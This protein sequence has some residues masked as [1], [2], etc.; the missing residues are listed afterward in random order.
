MGK[1][2]A[3]PGKALRRWRPEAQIIALSATVGNA[4]ELA[5]WL[6]ARLI[7]SE[8]RPVPLHLATCA[9]LTVEVRRVRQASTE[10]A[11]AASGP[12]P[13]PLIGPSSN[14]VAAVLDDAHA[15]GGQVLIFVNT[16]RSAVAEAK[17]LGK[18]MS[19]RLRKE[20]P[21]RSRI[22]DDLANGLEKKAEGATAMALAD[23][24]TLAT[25]LR[26]HVIDK[27]LEKGGLHSTTSPP[28]HYVAIAPMV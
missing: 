23:R 3:G 13:R 15:Q 8:W 18:R 1:A 4:E 19:K 2:H 5:G 27:G 12:P 10:K 17:R 26:G 28:A 22:L 9:D 7:T 20:D 14:P 25:S 11:E 16:R 24:S 6:Q 21:S